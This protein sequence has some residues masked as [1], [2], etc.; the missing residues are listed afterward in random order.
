MQQQKLQEAILAHETRNVALRRLFQ[1][2]GVD[3][4]EARCIECHF[5]A[6]GRDAAAAL[7]AGLTDRGFKILAQ[8]RAAQKED[9]NR[10]NVE[11]EIRQSIDLT[12]RRE[13]IEELVRLAGSHNST[14]DGWGTLV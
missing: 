6:G 8:G 2:K 11:G 14:F 10:W 4:S 1:E 5:W 9:R 3:L 12:M 7:A 13:F